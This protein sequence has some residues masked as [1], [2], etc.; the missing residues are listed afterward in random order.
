M[1][2]NGSSAS[3]TFKPLNFISKGVYGSNVC[4]KRNN[5]SVV[6]DFHQQQTSLTINSESTNDQTATT[7]SQK[8]QVPNNNKN[9]HHHVVIVD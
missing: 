1:S 7:Y 6:R 2:R 4:S 8:L 3:L 9:G 5:P